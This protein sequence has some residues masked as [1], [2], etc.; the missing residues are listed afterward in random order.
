MH[1]IINITESTMLDGRTIHWIVCRSV[2]VQRMKEGSWREKGGEWQKAHGKIERF[3]KEA[4]IQSD[5]N[6]RYRNH[7]PKSTNS[8]HWIHCGGDMT[9]VSRLFF[10][11]LFKKIRL[12][13]L[14]LLLLPLQWSL[15]KLFE[16]IRRHRIHHS[17][18]HEWLCCVCVCV[19][20]RF[21][22][23]AEDISQ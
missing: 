20:A 19:C 1:A 13:W 2:G 3:H 5:N 4:T 21:L 14:F 7:F 9:V 22:R 17:N 10:R 16:M 11:C 23:W 12:V 15:F 18:R 6:N 8:I